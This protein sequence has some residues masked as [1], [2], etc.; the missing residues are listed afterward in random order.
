M[1]PPIVQLTRTAST[2]SALSC[3]AIAK[4]RV[5]RAKSRVRMPRLGE[6]AEGGKRLGAGGCRRN[7]FPLW[8][9]G[10]YTQAVFGGELK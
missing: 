3:W 1:K 4:I 6:L 10:E 8:A 2:R 7:I 5:D 9:M